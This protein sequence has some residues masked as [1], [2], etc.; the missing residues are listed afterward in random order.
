MKIGR[1]N[2]FLILFLL[3]HPTLQ[4]M[5]HLTKWSRLGAIALGSYAYLR[6]QKPKKAYA[7][8]IFYK[9]DGTPLTQEEHKKVYATK[10]RYQFPTC[11]AY[12]SCPRIDE[13]RAIQHKLYLKCPG[14]RVS[15]IPTTIYELMFMHFLEHNKTNIAQATGGLLF[16]KKIRQCR[17]LGVCASL[18]SKM[19]KNDPQPQMSEPFSPEINT[20]PEVQSCHYQLNNHIVNFF[21]KNGIS[22]SP[23]EHEMQKLLST[24]SFFED[25]NEHFSTKTGEGSIILEHKPFLQQDISRAIALEYTAQ[26][27]KA[28][29]LW[30]TTYQGLI[31]D[32]WSNISNPEADRYYNP[33]NHSF[34]FSASLFGG[35]LMDVTACPYRILVDTDTYKD[36]FKKVLYTLPIPKRQYMHGSLQTMFYIPPL[37]TIVQ[38]TGH[39]EWFHPRTKLRS[40]RP[41]TGRSSGIF[42]REDAPTCYRI[43]PEQSEKTYNRICHYL[44]HKSIALRG[45]KPLSIALRGEKHPWWS[46]WMQRSPH[47]L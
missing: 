41:N 24:P 7:E 23:R 13:V 18:D 9:K 2:L 21:K 28:F 44:Q 5:H 31:D 39:G 34:S 27:K 38:L 25:A 42:M 46:W 15:F 17:V 8:T 43:P 11:L 22:L 45:E 12:G 4:S 33:K 32:R 36:K 6:L 40:D 30:R 26:K 14:I 47:L 3:V 16:E 19:G 37:A 1:G 10:L 20:L 35:Y 29:H